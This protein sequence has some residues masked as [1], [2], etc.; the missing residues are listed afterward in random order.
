MVIMETTTTET[1]ERVNTA[2]RTRRVQYT[3][4]DECRS[5][6]ANA[7]KVIVLGMKT[8]FI[9][10]L[11]KEITTDYHSFSFHSLQPSRFQLPGTI[12]AAGGTLV[13]LII[14]I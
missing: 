4:K 10:K 12:F 7:G 2:E 3:R 5:P 8:L 14:I 1:T 9:W 13:K 11:F 6:L